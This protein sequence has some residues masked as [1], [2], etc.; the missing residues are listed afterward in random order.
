M[1]VL[2]ILPLFLRANVQ[3][4][5]QHPGTEDRQH[6]GLADKVHPV[7]IGGDDL[8][9]RLV[10]IV[11]GGM[12]E[13][14]FPAQRSLDEPGRLE[15]ERRLAYVGITRARERLVLSYAESRRIH[16]VDTLGV[17]SRFLREIPADVI[18]E[19]RPRVSIRR[20][21]T[22][23]GGGAQMRMEESSSAFRLGQSVR[24]PHFGDGTIMDAEGAG[25][26]AR[27]QVNFE[28]AGPKWLVLAFAQLEAV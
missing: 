17:P 27:V 10:V 6:A 28:N 20:P 13:G 12:E 14:L 26:H 22:M 5:C 16:G 15:E 23:L 3:N 2:Q 8:E 25:S 7:S 9:H 4:C 11:V 1:S 24:H 21:A 19:V 18:R